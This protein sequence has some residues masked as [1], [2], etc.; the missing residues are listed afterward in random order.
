MG[1]LFSD[2]EAVRAQVRPPEVRD[3][4]G[5][6]EGEADGLEVRPGRPEAAVDLQHH[7]HDH[8]RWESD[9]HLHRVDG[10]GPLDRELGGLDELFFSSLDVTCQSAEGCVW[11]VP[12][13]P[14]DA[15]GRPH[16]R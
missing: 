7:H 12:R 5:D 4:H 2:F 15:L 13:P 10:C 1:G 11:Q 3:V 9:V 14:H 16:R 8:S 6:H